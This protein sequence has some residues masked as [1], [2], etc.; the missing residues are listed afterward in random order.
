MTKEEFIKKA[1]DLGYSDEAIQDIVADLDEMVKDGIKIPP[2][3]QIPLIEQP[4]Y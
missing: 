1:Q 3:E 4:V 2:Y